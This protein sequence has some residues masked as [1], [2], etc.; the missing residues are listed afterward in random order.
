MSEV[1]EYLPIGSIV[2]LKD[3]QKKVMI[4]GYTP[5][6]METK[7]KI[8]EYLGCVFPEGIIKSD[9]NILFDTKDIDKIFFKGFVNEEQENFITEVKEILENEEKKK[10]ILNEIK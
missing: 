2:L 3:A 5:I 9:E 8:Y 7:N 10:Q 6:D 1:K 4:T